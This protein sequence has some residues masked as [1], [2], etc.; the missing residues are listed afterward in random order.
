MSQH[1]KNFNVYSRRKY[2]FR[3]RKHQE[4]HLG[5]LTLG[6]LG[7]TA[8][9]LVWPQGTEKRGAGKEMRSKGKWAARTYMTFLSIVRMLLLF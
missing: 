5:E 8:R 3:Q 2:V 1:H 4:W 9:E 7:R 6:S